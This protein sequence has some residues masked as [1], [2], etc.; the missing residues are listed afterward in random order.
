MAKQ[1]TLIFKH[2]EKEHLG[3]DVFLVPYTIG[4]KYGYD[5]TIV[6][7]KT[8]TNSD[9]PSHIHGVKLHPIKPNLRLKWFPFW[10]TLPFYLYLLRKARNIDFLIRFHLQDHTYYQAFLYKLLNRKGILYVKCDGVSN[11][12]RNI[13]TCYPKLSWWSK[14]KFNILVNNVDRFSIETKKA[15]TEMLNCGYKK[16]TDKIRLLPNGFD[17]EELTRIGLKEKEYA[18]KNNTMITVGRLGD[19]AKNTEMILEALNGIDLKNWKVKLIGPIDESFKP[20]IE[21]FYR[22]NPDKRKNVIFTGPIYDKAELWNNYN[23]SKVFILSSRSE[24]FA[25]VLGEA[26]RFK[27]F[28]LSTDVGAA[29]DLTDSDKYGRT[30]KVCDIEAMR[31]EISDIINGKTDIDVYK[32]I[33]STSNSWDR[34]IDSLDLDG[35]IK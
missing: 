26:W 29:R 32:N 5:V 17:E 20:K 19:Y 24:S 16:F 11:S 10:R 15:Y 4:K 7:P 31:K 12:F 30:I 1:L 14:I 35:L 23:E 18:E 22:R 6:Y 25:L 9:F 28:I 21:N 33:D 27:C 13:L 8:K 3:K 2:F 34:L